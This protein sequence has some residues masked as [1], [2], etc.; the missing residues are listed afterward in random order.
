MLLVIHGFTEN[1]LTWRELFGTKVEARY[2]LL[3][4]H[5]WKPCPAT[6][7][8]SGVAADLVAKLPPG[9]H[10]VVGY[11]LGGRVALT[12]AVEHPQRVGRLILV[13]STAGL[14]DPAERAQRI[15]RDDHLA[16]ILEDEGISAFVALWEQQELLRPATPYPLRQCE[17]LRAMRLNHD[18]RGLA[19]VLRTLGV[20]TMVGI[21]ERLAA[22]T[23]RTL[24]IA[25]AEDR[26][27]V[28]EMTAMAAAIP[29]ARFQAIAGSGHGVHREQPYALRR[30]IENALR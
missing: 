12:L 25:G 11:S 8:L 23:A 30:T 10:D 15:R 26:R 21:R 2:A 17:T 22:V 1:D 6:T 4:G 24:L 19:G 9:A 29:E 16:R 18:P 28:A 14:A 20:G 7:S 13:S 27:Y 5:G 3:P